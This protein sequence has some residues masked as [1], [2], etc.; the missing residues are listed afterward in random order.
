MPIDYKNYPPNWKELSHRIRFERA[1]GKCEVCFA[2]HGVMIYRN[3]DKLENY[4]TMD[5]DGE[6]YLPD[7]KILDGY[8]FE[9]T[10]AVRVVLTVAHLDHDVTNNDEDNLKALCQLCHLRYDA[11]YHA[12]NARVT[13]ARN[14]RA[15]Q[16]TL[17]SED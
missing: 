16:M 7:G 3:P 5:S 12:Q 10:K 6:L 4:V 8:G 17:F 15:G 11:Q 13:R 14:R 1:K 9:Y 2:P